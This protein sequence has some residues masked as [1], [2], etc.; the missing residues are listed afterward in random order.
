[1]FISRKTQRLYVRRAFQPILESA[2]TILDADRPIGTHVSTAMERTNRDTAMRW[3]VVSL[4]G[5]RPDGDMVE[6]HGPARGGR[7]PGIEIGED[8][9]V[10]LLRGPA[11]EVTAGMQDNLT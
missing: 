7:G 4:D 10:D 11:A 6:P 1:M 3:I 2:V 5:G 9:L 8:G